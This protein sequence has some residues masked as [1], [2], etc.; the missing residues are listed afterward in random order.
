[1]HFAELEL[2]KRLLSSLDE[3]EYTRP[4][5]IQQQVVPAMMEGLDVLA[6]A[7]TGTGKTAA[8]LLPALQHLLD[9]P[10]AKSGP[11]RVLIIVPTRELATQVLESARTLCKNNHLDCHALTGGVAHT[12]Y[13]QMLRQNIDLLVA[14]PGRL[15]EY[16]NQELINPREVELLVIDEADRTLEMGFGQDVEIIAAETR[17]RKHTALFSAT[18]EGNLVEDFSTRLLN[19]PVSLRADY[20]P[21]R[22]KN[23]LHQWVHLADDLNHKRQLLLHYLKDESVT[24]AIV[25]AKTRERLVELGDWLR[26][27]GLLPIELRGSMDQDKRDNAL[28]KFATQEK[29]ILLASDVAARGIDISDISHVINYDMPRTADVYVH[30]IGRTARAGRKGTAISLVEAHDMPQLDRVERYT[31][32]TIDRRF[33][34]TLRPKHKAARI[35]PKVSKKDKLKKKKAAEKDEDVKLPKQRL[36]DKKNKG[37]PRW[38]KAKRAESGNNNDTPTEK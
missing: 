23:R 17:W 2:D 36:R 1:M 8:Y 19:D 11:P 29:A 32:E 13:S 6:C 22:E 18:L 14:T 16:L 34:K 31:D 15:I 38:L 9:F 5:T 37:A 12:E 26:S 7:P 3:M 20:V 30:R 33:V 35:T 27:Q 4:T 28:Q 21:R 10:R 25:F 24:K